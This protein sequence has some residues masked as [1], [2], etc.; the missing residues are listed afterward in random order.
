MRVSWEPAKTCWP[1]DLLSCIGPLV[2]GAHPGEMSEPRCGA[3]FV[4]E[5]IIA[6]LREHDTCLK[7]AELCREHEISKAT[8]LLLDGEV[9]LQ[10]GACPYVSRPNSGLRGPSQAYPRL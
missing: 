8:F 9:R 7:T 2:C 3:G 1:N 6:V 10:H 4:E 5:E